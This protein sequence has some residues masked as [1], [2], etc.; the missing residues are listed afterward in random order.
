MKYKLLILGLILV[1]IDQ[2]TKI[3]SIGKNFTLIP[4]IFYVKYSTNSGLIFG[5][6]SN[7][8]FFIYILPIIIIGILIY[9]YIK[10]TN[11]RIGLMLVI[12]GIFGNLI[13][14]IIFILFKFIKWVSSSCL[15]K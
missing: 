7:N 9:F 1:I 5:F 13:G 4:K 11:L 12:S 2:L 10:N 6:F 15:C 8:F 14:R 3:L